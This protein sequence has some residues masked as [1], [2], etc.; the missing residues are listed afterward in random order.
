MNTYGTIITR[1]AM[2]QSLLCPAARLS[3]KE[4]LVRFLALLWDF[5]LAMSYFTVYTDKAFM[6]LSLLC[7]ALSSVESLHQERPTNCVR[8]PP[9]QGSALQVPNDR[10]G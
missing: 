8:A 9:L 7:S 5:S 2:L 10:G 4:L 3:G 6:S 1:I